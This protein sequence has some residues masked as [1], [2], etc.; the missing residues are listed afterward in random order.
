MMKE[1][2]IVRRKLIEGQPVMLAIDIQGSERPAGDLGAAIPTMA[3][4]AQRMGRAA[5][6]IR[7]ARES[8]IPIIFFQEIHRPDLVDIGRELDGA[9]D[10]H[11]IEGQ[12]G[13]EIS[14]EL[15]D[16]RPEDIVIQKRRYSCFFGTDL[17]ILLKGLKADTLIMVGALTDVCV[18]Y[19]FVD[20][21]QRDYFCRVAEDCVCGS[22][23]AAHEC[24]LRAMEYLQAG[25][26]R[27]SDEIRRAFAE[28]AREAGRKS[29]G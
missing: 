12:A 22:S 28:F 23:E 14:A 25:A 26:R 6:L 11:D 29:P 17:E 2:K 21:H 4:Y 1:G 8:A 15:V 19:T 10:I 5:A 18:H 13:T 20:G 9:E 27:T 16:L 24:A 3:D 7:A